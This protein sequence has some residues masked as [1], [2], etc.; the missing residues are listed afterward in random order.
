MECGRVF[1]GSVIEYHENQWG[2]DFTDIYREYP[3]AVDYEESYGKEFLKA[4]DIV[5]YMLEKTRAKSV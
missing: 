1:A 4:Q 5:K 3:G 2:D